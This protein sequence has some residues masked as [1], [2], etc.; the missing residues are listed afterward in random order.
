MEDLKT[1]KL[2]E[3]LYYITIGVQ[4]DKLSYT[5]FSEDTDKDNPLIDK[6]TLIGALQKLLAFQIEQID[7]KSNEKK[8]IASKNKK[9][10]IR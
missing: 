1:S 2:K 9:S 7:I 8:D 10:K 5:V 6:F 4:G 3:K